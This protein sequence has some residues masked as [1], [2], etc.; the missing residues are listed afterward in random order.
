MNIEM[1]NVIGEGIGR[2]GKWISL[3][4]ESFYVLRQWR[5]INWLTLWA[6]RQ[7]CHPMSF[8]TWYGTEWTCPR[9]IVVGH[10]Q[11]GSYL[12]A[13]LSLFHLYLPWAPVYPSIHPP[14]PLCSHSVSDS[15]SPSL[16]G[17]HGLHFTCAAFAKHIL[18]FPFW[19]LA[20]V[21]NYTIRL[22][23]RLMRPPLPA[24]YGS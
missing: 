2:E 3:W 13:S 6:Q 18:T 24:T 17:P 23:N 20:I 21:H 11:Y 1:M 5:E 12:L 19:F 16:F 14:P 8:V 9:C 4:D 15:L 7:N 22:L 10:E